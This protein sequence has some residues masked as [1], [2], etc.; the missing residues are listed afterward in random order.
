MK[1]DAVARLPSLRVGARGI[2]VV[3]VMGLLVA[4]SIQPARQLLQQ[5]DR[6]G[7]V[8]AQLDATQRSNRHLEQQIARLNNDDFIEQRARSQI[9]L[10]RPGETAIVMMPPSRKEQRKH[11]TALRAKQPTAPP[12]P[13]FLE[14][15]LHFIGII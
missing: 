10:V 2:V 4:M 7:G 8:T 6:I 5:R 9:G 15:V 14:G 13:S 3:L 11:R 12:P 1:A